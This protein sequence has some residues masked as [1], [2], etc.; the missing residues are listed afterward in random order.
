MS[1]QALVDA[2]ADVN[3]RSV[4][5]AH[6]QTPLMTAIQHANGATVR[7]LI[8]LG[9]DPRLQDA[10]GN[11][12]CEWARRFQQPREVMTLV[13]AAVAIAGVPPFSGYHSKDAILLAVHAKHPWMFW[14]GVVT[15]GMTAFYVF[16][17][18]FLCFFGS[19]RGTAHPHESPLSMTSISRLRS[20]MR[21]AM[22]GA[23]PLPFIRAL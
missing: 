14:V 12:S 11:D 7:K 16:R 21:G 10:N 4:A 2:G 9:A 20:A 3:Q 1:L 6:N 22:T 23:P 19:Y 5:Q 15:A 17:A 18:I 13:C 8:E